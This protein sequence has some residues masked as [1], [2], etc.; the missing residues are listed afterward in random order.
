[1]VR[2]ANKLLA[3]LCQLC[4]DERE[5]SRKVQQGSLHA[6]NQATFEE[7]VDPLICAQ[8]E[9]E[10]VTRATEDLG[11][12]CSVTCSQRRGTRVVWGQLSSSHRYRVT[13]PQ[14]TQDCLVLG[15]GSHL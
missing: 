7:Q 9:R 1:M 12:C 11:S 15:C 6:K 10:K 4:F 14:S 3:Q 8:V 2:Q 5:A 13:E